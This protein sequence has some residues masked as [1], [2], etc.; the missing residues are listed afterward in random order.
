MNFPLSWKLTVGLAT[1][2]DIRHKLNCQKTLRRQCKVKPTPSLLQRLSDLEAST[3]VDINNSKAA[4]FEATII[5]NHLQSN[6]S[7]YFSLYQICH[8]ARHSSPSHVP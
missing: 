8:Q 2:H 5:D 7:L 6:S 4:Q 3:Q 1:N